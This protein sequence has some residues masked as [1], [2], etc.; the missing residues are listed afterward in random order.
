MFDN[1]LILADNS[2]QMQNV[3]QFALDLFPN[4]TYHLLSVIN[5]GAF[6]SYY[7]K[8]AYKEM[9]EISEK[10]LDELSKYFRD[11]RE[12]CVTQISVGDPTN[13]ILTY[14][15]QNVISLI[16]LETHSGIST[17]KVKLGKTTASLITHS[18]IPILLVSEY[19]PKA[20]QLRILHPTTGSKYSEK[21]TEI[22]AK[23]AKYKQSKLEVLL[24]RSDPR[25]RDRA[26]EIIAREGIVAEYSLSEGNEINSVVSKSVNADIIVGSRGS[27]RPYYKLRFFVKSFALDPTIKLLVA[28]LPKPLLLVCD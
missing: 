10:S 25:I 26:Q 5:L 23:M 18:H 14:A 13:K 3:A 8:I 1:I 6:S 27:P 22:A 28:L 9:K 21:A 17:N 15:K 16:I 12:R 2:S 24:L 7:A 11:K 20:E 19:F 4:S